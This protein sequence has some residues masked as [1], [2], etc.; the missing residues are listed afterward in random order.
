MLVELLL[1]FVW[2]L[3]VVRQQEVDPVEDALAVVATGFAAWLDLCDALVAVD[4]FVLA[5]DGRAWHVVR[6]H[7]RLSDVLVR[8]FVLRQG[9]ET[10]DCEDVHVLVVDHE[11]NITE[12]ASCFECV[13]R[14]LPPQD[15]IDEDLGDLLQ[16]LE[17]DVFGPQA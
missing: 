8:F 5:F 16:R 12:A 1:S 3:V 2:L 6:L 13:L 15:Q 14:N 17:V 10:E 7:A 4:L 11:A 9:V